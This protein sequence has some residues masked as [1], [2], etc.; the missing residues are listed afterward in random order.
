[1]RQAAYILGHSQTEIRRLVYQAALLRPTT[2]RLLRSAGIARGMRV[3][4][5]GCGAG[6]VAMLAAEM[7]G[8]SGSVVGIDRNGRVIRIARERAQAAGLRHVA[9]MEA[10]A[11][12]FSDPAS[13]DLAIG[14]YVLVHQADPVALLRAAARSVRPGGIVAF[15][16]IAL[17]GET[18]S[19]PRVQLWDQVTE[20]CL[21]AFRAAAPHFDAAGRLVEH[22][23]NAGLPHPTLFCETPVGG[24]PQ[25]P[26]YR[27]A[28]ETLRSVL[29]KLAEMGMVTAESVAIDTLETR[30]RTAVLAAQSQI[31]GPAQI[32]AWARA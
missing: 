14:R 30:L 27:W 10:S 16:E 11:D 21:L 26:L 22:F 7:V 24:G 31:L 15:H 20:W 3:L 13:F 4:D 18:R 1:M 9:F 2:E 17:H 12:D 29:P 8:A 32:C 6:D 23:C 25:S 28:T 5:L 19:L